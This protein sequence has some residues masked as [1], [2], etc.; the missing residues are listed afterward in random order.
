MVQIID[1][2]MEKEPAKRFRDAAE[3][4]RAFREI[5]RLDGN[6]RKA[7]ILTAA[8]VLLEVVLLVGGIML[9]GTG[10]ARLRQEQYNSYVQLLNNAQQEKNR[11]N[12]AEALDMTLQ[13]QTLIDTRME[14]YTEE[15]AVYYEIAINTLDPEQRK[16]AFQACVAQIQELLQADTQGG[17]REEWSKAYFV[18]A[19][20]CVELENYDQ[21]R[22]WYRKA[23]AYA[24]T[25]SCYR[26]LI[27]ACTFDQDMEG[28]KAALEEMK[29][30]LPGAD[31]RASSELI[32]AELC[33]L[34]QDYSGAIGHYR[35][36]FQS[37]ND[38]ALLRRGYMAASNACVYGG[39]AYL[40]QR[41]QFLEEACQRLPSAAGVYTPLLAGAYYMQAYQDT[42]Q[43]SLW[44]EK[45]LSAY[46]SIQVQFLG[47]EDRLNM[48]Q[49]R[50]ALGQLETAEADL[51]LMAQLYQ[52]DYRVYMQLSYLYLTRCAL[53]GNDPAIRTK[54]EDAY[55]SAR[56]Y[57]EKSGKNDADM[58]QFIYSWQQYAPDED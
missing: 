58:L 41:I 38:E 13:A 22:K 46:E 34:Q 16:E 39:N 57:Y 10:S 30:A 52:E 28:A 44:L 56:A 29:T 55:R 37:T 11:G 25:E 51:L 42:A 32:Q 21:A 45:A 9:M 17:S 54:A 15:A 35:N 24:P 1:R 47:L 5:H 14:A 7:R 20:S 27:C 33:Y 36:L 4:G 12:Y 23:I 43:Q 31:L 8:G 53:D 50:I 3:L 6:Y 19:E 48:N 40:L 2:A 49:L 26:G 18:G